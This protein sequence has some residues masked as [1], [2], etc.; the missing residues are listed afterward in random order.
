MTGQTISH[1]T[2]TDKL[3]EGRLFRTESGAR[4]RNAVAPK[5]RW[6]EQASTVSFP[7]HSRS[8]P[9]SVGANQS[10]SRVRGPAP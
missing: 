8:E 7:Q 6:R 5:P 2:T 4:A 1:Y 9:R 3:G 10:A